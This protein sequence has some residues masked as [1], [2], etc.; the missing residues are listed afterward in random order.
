MVHG[1]RAWHG[2]G[3][4]ATAV[5]V[6]K[7]GFCQRPAGLLAQ[8][9][10]FA[11]CRRSGSEIANGNGSAVEEDQ[12]DRPAHCSNLVEHRAA[13][14]LPNAEHLNDLFFP[15]RAR[16]QVLDAVLSGESRIETGRLLLRLLFGLHQ[17]FSSRFMVAGRPSP[18]RR[19]PLWVGSSDRTAAVSRRSTTSCHRRPRT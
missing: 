5:D 19:T 9:P 10:A 7:E 6:A 12:N 14:L 1:E 18:L 4:L 11:D 15:R 13:L 17:G 2:D 16:R 3:K 8:I